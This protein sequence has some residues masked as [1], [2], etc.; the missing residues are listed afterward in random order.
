VDAK[1][2]ARSLAGNRALIGA[3]L[4]LL[5]KLASR[6]WVG[7]QQSEAPGAQ[8]LARAT[9]ARDLGIAAGVL[10]T[11]ESRRKR[12]AW[13]RAQLLA[14]AVDFGATLAVARS[15]PPSARAVGLGMSGGSTLVAAWLVRELG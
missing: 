13:L 10:T 14:D 8:L 2:V 12:G 7:P 15:L 1:L 4:A 3:G 9:G 5:P 6:G 11:V